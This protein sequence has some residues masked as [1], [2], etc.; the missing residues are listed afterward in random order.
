MS[1][2]VPQSPRERYG[3]RS[4]LNDRD[5]L[6]HVANIREAKSLST[7][8]HD[9]SLSPTRGKQKADARPQRKRKV[10][11]KIKIKKK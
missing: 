4:A 3:K 11:K 9:Q 2:S 6:K 7:E 10:K 1:D 5:A 8:I